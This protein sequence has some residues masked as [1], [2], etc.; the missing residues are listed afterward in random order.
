MLHTHAPSDQEPHT[1]AAAQRMTHLCPLPTPSPGAGLR[2]GPRHI[3]R[4]QQDCYIKEYWSFPSL[5][6]PMHR[7]VATSHCRCSVCASS[8]RR[9]RTASSSLFSRLAVARHKN[10]CNAYT[11]L[12]RMSTRPSV[13]YDFGQVCSMILVTIAVSVHPSLHREKIILAKKKKKK[14]IGSRAHC[15][16]AMAITN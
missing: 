1:T 6:R 9:R 13:L 8:S 15:V 3:A 12:V 7:P 2:P 14:E 5:Q 10:N 16:S 11:S 4:H